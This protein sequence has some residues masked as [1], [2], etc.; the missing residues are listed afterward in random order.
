MRAGSLAR[1]F[2]CAAAIFHPVGG[3][4]AFSQTPDN[5]SKNAVQVQMHNV[6]YHFTEQTAV[7]ILSLQGELLPTKQEGI[8]IF[9][10][11]M[12]FILAIRAAEISINTTALASVLNQYVLASPDSPLKQIS[13]SSEGKT[14]K[15]KGHLHSKGDLPFEMDGT[16]AATP[17]GEIRIHAENIKAAHL[18]VKGLMDLLDVKIANLISANKVKGIRAEGNDLFLNPAQI[19]PPPQIRG[20]ITDVQLSGNEIVQIF[21]GVAAAPKRAGNYM[22]YEGAQLRFNKLTMSDTDLTIVDMDPQDPFDFFLDHYVE[23]L[24]AGYSKTTLKYGLRVYMRDYNKIR[25]SP[26]R[27]LPHSN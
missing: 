14:L 27:A 24:A 2:C 19:L 16:L 3:S 8:P 20:K 4:I 12:S 7:H 10:D 15:I 9:D 5:S 1:V 23:Q 22:S 13:L 6:M 11:R 17:E 25:N 26:R 18:P 21:G